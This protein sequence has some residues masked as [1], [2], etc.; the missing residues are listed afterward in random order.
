MA[1]VVAELPPE[2]YELPP[3]PDTSLLVT[4]DD[5][6]SD[7]FYVEKQQ[8]LLTEPLYSSWS[9]TQKKPFLASANVGLFFAPTESPLAPDVMLSMDVPPVT[10]RLEDDNRS[11]F[12]WVIGKMPE[13]VI[14]IVSD[15]RGK[16]DTNKMDRYRRQHIPYYVIYDPYQRLRAGVLRA[17]A[18]SGSKYRAIEPVFFD[19]LGLGLTLWKGDYEGDTGTWLRWCDLNGGFI[20]TGRER[21]NAEKERADTEKGR[22][23]AAEEK[24]RRLIERLKQLGEAVE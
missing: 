1:P 5:T 21:A 4:Q 13:V 24:S 11:Y 8:R 10:D 20:P 6:P 3:K 2:V 7:N 19:D 23:D 18:L 9:L 12:A 16:E 15:R 22:A 14:E 17:F